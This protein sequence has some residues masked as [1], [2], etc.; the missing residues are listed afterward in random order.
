M[1][2]TEHGH[3][4]RNDVEQHTPAEAAITEA[5]RKVEEAGCHPLLTDAVVLLSEARDKV[6]DFV[7]LEPS[8]TDQEISNMCS[9]HPAIHSRHP[10]TQH[11]LNFFK[12]DHLPP[13]LQ[14]VSRPFRE[15]AYSLA[16]KAPASPETTVALRKL[17]ESKDAA[18]RASL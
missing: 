2:M 5:M 16:D 11:V 12:Y 4:R 9:R 6:A 17:L 14:A 18:V 13:T 3:P 15:L 7:E 1:K 10:A 8:E